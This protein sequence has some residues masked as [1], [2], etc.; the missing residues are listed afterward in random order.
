[1]PT[2]TTGRYLAVACLVIVAVCYGMSIAVHPAPAG[3]DSDLDAVEK[4]AAH[5][6]RTD[7]LLVLNL[8]ALLF[9]VAIVLIA[10]LAR[11]G[12]RALSTWAGWLGTMVGAATGMVVATDAVYAAAARAADRQAAVDLLDA[13]FEPPVMIVYLVVGLAG[14]L[15]AFVLLAIA[16]IRAKVVAWPFAVAL[17]VGYLVGGPFGAPVTGVISTVLLLVGFGACAAR[18]LRAGLPDPT[19]PTAT[20]GAQPAASTASLGASVSG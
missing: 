18:I 3:G 4:F 11:P 17:P 15:A 10:L 19:A 13:F 6:G 8:G 1:M 9:P 7:A 2:R 20:P 16:L 14:G 12:A 5:P